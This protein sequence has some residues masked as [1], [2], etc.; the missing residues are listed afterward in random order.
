MALRGEFSCLNPADILFSHIANEKEQE[1]VRGRASEGKRAV[2]SDGTSLQLQN[3]QEVQ[4]QRQLTTPLWTRLIQPVRLHLFH[5][6][7]E[8]SR[9]RPSDCP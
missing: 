6:K 3:Q 5:Q 2:V 1:K 8:T 4:Q 7:T 9:L